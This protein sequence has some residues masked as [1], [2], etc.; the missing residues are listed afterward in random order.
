MAN[1]LK[2]FWGYFLALVGS[3]SLNLYQ[4][5]DRNKLKALDAEKELEIKEAELQKLQA[6][7]YSAKAAYLVSNPN[8]F[9]RITDVV[10]NPNYKDKSVAEIEFEIQ[11]VKAQIKHLKKI[12]NYKW[13]FS[14]NNS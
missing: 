2:I 10:D 6:D 5:L 13:P 11:K 14:K 4:Y 9:I 3:L 8:E 1:F 12:I 7:F